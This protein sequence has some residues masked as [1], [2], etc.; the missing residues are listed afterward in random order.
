MVKF[1]KTGKVR[2]KNIYVHNIRNR[3]IGVG[4]INILKEL[5]AIAA[6][7]KKLKEVRIDDGAVQNS[8]LFWF[9]GKILINQQGITNICFVT[10]N[11]SINLKISKRSTNIILYF[12]V[13]ILNIIRNEEAIVYKVFSLGLSHK[14]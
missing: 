13:N 12:V 11:N 10:F 3:A 14:F 6:V 8:I 1:N 5:D 2:L 4:Q 9:I 7:Y